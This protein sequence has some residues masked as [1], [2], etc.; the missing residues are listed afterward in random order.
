MSGSSYNY[1]YTKFQPGAESLPVAEGGYLADMI[2]SLRDHAPGS[3]ALADL[4]RVRSLL[5]EATK[6]GAGMRDVMHA[7]EWRDSGDIG[8]D[9]LDEVIATYE[10]GGRSS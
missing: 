8:D 4:E 9:Q 5:Q 10:S 3:R 6:L 2:E 1:L 7:I